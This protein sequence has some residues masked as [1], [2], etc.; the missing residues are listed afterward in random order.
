MRSMFRHAS[1]M[2]AL[3]LCLVAA[4]LL[5]ACGG[6]SAGSLALD[7]KGSA[8]T[9]AGATGPATSDGAV[10]KRVGLLITEDEIGTLPQWQQELLSDPGWNQPYI[11]PRTGTELDPPTTAMLEEYTQRELEQG[12][13]IVPRTAAQSA[14]K[15][16]SWNDQGVFEPGW[17]VFHAE[18]ADVARS[19]TPLFG[20]ND[21][22]ENE[23]NGHALEDVIFAVPE[24]LA[25]VVSYV[26]LGHSTANHFNATGGSGNDYLSA[27]YQLYSDD[28]NAVPSDEASTATFGEISYRADLA[29]GIGP[30]GSCAGATGHSVRGKF[31]ERFSGLYDALPDNDLDGLPDAAPL[32]DILIAPAG[33]VTGPL[34]NSGGTTANYQEFYFG[35]LGSCY[36]GSWIIAIESSSSSCGKFNTLAAANAGN[37]LLV[38][39][40]YGLMLRRWLAMQP[41][42]A[43]GAWDSWLGWPVMGPVAA[44][45]GDNN[46]VA[47]LGTHYTWGIWF[48]HGFMWW[49]DYDQAAYPATPDEIQIYHFTGDHVF[50][51]QSGDY[52]DR[53]DPPVYYGGN[54]PLSVGVYVDG[55]R[56]SAD[57]LGDPDAT[58]WLSVPMDSTSA[59]YMIALP[60]NGVH[61]VDLSLY[62]QAY[63]GQTDADCNY[64]Y[65]IWAFRDGTIQ[66]ATFAYDP[67]QAFAEHTYGSATDN[68]EATYV[69]RVQV[70]D[71]A[72]TIAYGDSLPIH[73][74]HDPVG[75]GDFAEYTGQPEIIS[76][77]PM[78][79]QAGNLSKGL[80]TYTWDGT[81]THAF[82]FPN[83][84][85]P[86]V[87]RNSLLYPNNVITTSVPPHNDWINGNDVDFQFPWY[88]YIYDP[89]GSLTGMSLTGD[90][91]LAGYAGLLLEDT[92]G[93]WVRA[94]PL[95]PTYIYP[96]DPRWATEVNLGDVTAPVWPL[97]PVAGWYSSTYP[98][99]TGDETRAH[100]GSGYG[101][102]FNSAVHEVTAEA[103]VHWPSSLTY[104]GF[105]G[106]PASDPVLYW[107]MYPGQDVLIPGTTDQIP[108][109]SVGG[110]GAY[111]DYFDVDPSIINIWRFGNIWNRPQFDY[112]YAPS[113]GRVVT[114]DYSSIPGWDPDLNLNGYADTG[115]KFPLRCRLFV[116]HS[117]YVTWAG[118]WPH[119]LQD[120]GSD[121]AL[122]GD[123]TSDGD[124]IEGGTYMVDY[125]PAVPYVDIYDDPA[126]PDPVMGTTITDLGGNNYAVTL[127]YGIQDGT[128]N[129]AVELDAQFSPYAGPTPRESFGLNNPAQVYAVPDPTP[130]S[131]GLRTAT[132]T[133]NQP[134]PGDYW[135]ALRVT[136]AAGD[137]DMFWY[138]DYVHINWPPTA[139]LVADSYYGNVPHTVNFDATGSYDTNGWIVDY[140]WDFDGDL[141]FNEPSAEASAHGNASPSYTF[142][143]AG[144]YTV[145]VRV[146]DNDG[147]TDTDDVSITIGMP[148]AGWQL[149]TVDSAGD[150]GKYTSLAEVNGHPSI[151][152]IGNGEARYAWASNATGIG[153]T[154]N[155]QTLS[156]ALE[157]QTTLAVVGGGT[158]VPGVVYKR[159]NSTSFGL[160]EYRYS[161]N[162]DGSAGWGIVTSGTAINTVQG[163]QS[164][165]F[166]NGGPAIA[167][168]RRV[169]STDYELRYWWSTS[170]D[171]S[172]LGTWNET[173]IWT[174]SGVTSLGLGY[175]SS[176][177]VVNGHPAVSFY[178]YNGTDGN[179]HYAY[180]SLSDGSGTWAP[181][182]VDSVA[183]TGLMTSLETVA[184]GNLGISY[185]E[186]N[187][188]DLW[189]AHTYS[190]DGI[191][192]SWN[193]YFVDGSGNDVG[194]WTSLIFAGGYP[195]I[196]YYDATNGD[197]K[198]ASSLSPIGTSAW[199]PTTIDSAGDV[200]QY[201]SAAVIA[202]QPAISYYDATNGDLKYA[203]YFP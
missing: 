129:Y 133:V 128:P 11:E 202:G 61:T 134:N 45:N 59:Y 101:L 130:G 168:H 181:I 39:P 124:F 76:V 114:F 5:S 127:Y 81:G 80:T 69:V 103:I 63:G 150:V 187:N 87:Y 68:L 40:L 175:F 18:Y 92:D 26:S 90:E 154:W 62:A 99:D 29:P 108:Y 104:W 78:V 156:P 178:K 66:P 171:G 35:S 70:M 107:S 17:E 20:C 177:D 149:T 48:E 112:S 84:D 89:D 144:S 19:A 117:D 75:P 49:V 102:V 155:W 172:G 158:P 42:S 16:A 33:D 46:Y 1:M 36:A 51:A 163:S 126:Q 109:D 123:L 188:G 185:Y 7:E 131:N 65:Y 27:V 50:C 115:D 120:P 37:A 136:D 56:F 38:R 138:G 12:V 203:R 142:T 169:N 41:L 85:S 191:S 52:Y 192:G 4:G 55:M 88:A 182:T 83:Q 151:S 3:T 22:P 179:C 32:Y 197:L 110:W 24:P 189:Y 186:H 198:Y 193:R 86:D 140:E 153:A 15:T 31:W 184:S 143:A 135:Y 93:S 116:D 183:G 105:W 152:Y 176:L 96:T 167:Y 60:N 137:Q 174:V 47:A 82:N 34:T 2:F 125:G 165:A 98:G 122:T 157:Q 14:T 166:V 6:G 71:A 196:S 159:D 195:G 91:V 170:A 77:T 145:T 121:P 139:V 194:Q 162:A 23:Y 94:D 67:A 100:Y 106:I 9:A 118:T 53:I 8:A 97:A 113:A 13:S 164:L 146:T 28:I 10:T 57:Y 79:W 58:D 74:G 161:I 190:L 141:V 72:G 64:R 148:L 73:I 147:A 201:T 43:A 180:S 199:T 30:G 119:H 132:V 173:P 95:T 54:G 44:N 160:L 111:R 25:H 200:G 21:N